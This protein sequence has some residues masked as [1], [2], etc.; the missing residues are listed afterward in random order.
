MLHNMPHTQLGLFY[1]MRTTNPLSK[2]LF[3]QSFRD[4]GGHGGFLGNSNTPQPSL[5][6]EAD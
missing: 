2:R 1:E 4:F 6:H 5:F 3:Y